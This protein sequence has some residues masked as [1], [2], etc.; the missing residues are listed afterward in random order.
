MSDG[1]YQRRVARARQTP[2]PQQQQ[3]YPQ[4][5]QAY[6][7]QQQ[8]RPPPGYIPQ[9]PVPTTIG[10]L[11]EQMQQWHGGKAH[12][13][14]PHPCPECGS[15]QYFSRTGAEARRGPPPAPHCFACGY[16]GMFDQGLASTWNA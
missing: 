6:Y 12:Q 9:Q 11:W 1:W 3:Q 4:Q 14:D 8:Q 10:N 2:A 7:P 5:R 15:D 13:V 16:N